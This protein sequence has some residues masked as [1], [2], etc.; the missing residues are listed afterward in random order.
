MI[1]KN[2]QV[3]EI[4]ERWEKIWM[5]EENSLEARINAYSILN[6]INALADIYEW[7]EDLD[8]ETMDDLFTAYNTNFR[9]VFPEE[10][11]KV[12]EN[13]RKQFNELLIK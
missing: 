4:Y 2:K 5:N 13:F 1:I 6:I 9:P 8:E 3:N 12:L 11:P 7:D 10:I